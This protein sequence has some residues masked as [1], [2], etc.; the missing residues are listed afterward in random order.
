MGFPNLKVA[1]N[2]SEK[3]L[4]QQN[5]VEVVR[6]AIKNCDYDPHLLELELTETAIL[7][8]KIISIIKEF[9]LMGISLAVDDFGTGYS[10]LSYLK[11]FAIDKLKI[12]QSFV[13]DI[14][15]NNDSIAIVSA[16]LAMSKELKVITLA[17]GVETEEQ[18]KFL[19][20]K[21]CDYIQGYY[22]SKPLDSA[23]FTQYLLINQ[24]LHQ[25]DLTA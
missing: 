12:D 23:N 2:L 21:G 5:F 17:E 8:E 7:D 14:P 6:N 13:R 18:L 20:T 16:I 10:G 15:G 3:Q 25:K 9:K 1:V 19:Q 4:R 24:T 22:F 11:R